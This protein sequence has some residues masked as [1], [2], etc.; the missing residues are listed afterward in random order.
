MNPAAPKLENTLPHPLE[1]SRSGDSVSCAIT[2]PRDLVF[3]EGHFPD[4]PVLPGVVLI[5]WML[6]AIRVLTGR[7]YASGEITQARFMGVVRGGRSATLTAGYTRNRVK[8]RVVYE[9]KTRA[10]LAVPLPAE[11]KPS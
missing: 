8:A 11:R 5:A 3:F 1:W 2:C 4:H 9:G 10:S 7:D 6:E